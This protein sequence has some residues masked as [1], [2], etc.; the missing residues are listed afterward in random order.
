VQALGWRPAEG[1]VRLEGFTA[2]WERAL[3]GGRELSG[4]S[5]L[6][7]AGLADGGS[8]AVVRTELVAQGWK[9]EDADD[10]SSEEEEEEAASAATASLAAIKA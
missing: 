10:T 8:L 2:P 4:G 3:A 9:I 7:Q 5:T 1:C 6:E